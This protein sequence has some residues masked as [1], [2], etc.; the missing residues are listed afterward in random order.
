MQ[1]PNCSHTDTP[2]AFSNPAKCPSCGVYY[3][4]ALANQVRKEARAASET[5]AASSAESGAGK[6][7]ILATVKESVKEGRANRAAAEVVAQQR[8]APTSAQPV[9]IV[10]F[11]MSFWSMVQFMVKW[12]LAAIPAA[13]I[14]I[15]IF[16]GLVSIFGLFGMG[17]SPRF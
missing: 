13:L 15:L 8:R 2:Q 3:E 9:V 5:S 1:C 10:D 11:N 6:A 4:K 7:S 14:L 17:S 16:W 12:A